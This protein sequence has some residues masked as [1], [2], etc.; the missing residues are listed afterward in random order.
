[1]LFSV[2]GKRKGGRKKFEKE[3]EKEGRTEGRKGGREEERM[4]IS[5]LRRLYTK[6]SIRDSIHEKN[7]FST[8]DD[9]REIVLTEI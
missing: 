7:Y 3:S 4:R 9:R 5:Q 6:N 2:L 1:M 8:S